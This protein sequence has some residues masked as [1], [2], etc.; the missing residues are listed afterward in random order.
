MLSLGLSI[1]LFT[2]CTAKNPENNGKISVVAVSFAEY[3]FARAVCGDAAEVSMIMKPGGEYHGYEPSF[4][5]V[6]KIAASDV[7]LYNGGESDSWIRSLLK[8][9]NFEDVMAISLIDSAKLLQKDSDGHTHSHSHD[10]H[11]DECED[12]R[13]FD[14]HIWLDFDNAI[15]MVNTICNAVCEKDEKNSAVYK[16][17]AQLYCNQIEVLK[18]IALDLKDNKE[19]D[20]IIVGDRFPYLYLTEYV[21]VKH[22][23]AIRGCGHETEA[24]PSVI[25][26]IIDK[27]REDSIEIIFCDKMSDPSI[28]QTITKE[29]T[30]KILTLN[31]CQTISKTDF[32]EGKTYINL[33]EE[34]LRNLKEALM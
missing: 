26:E 13:E 4:S 2:G 24:N 11:S 21:G 6:K 3:D 31:S 32:S 28:A 14:E 30:A 8:S 22:F 33:M 25:I 12:Y 1:I 5:D 20:Y 9:G 23:S 19:K 34:N 10:N 29:T 15:S 18:S 16:E 17:N 27:I 7:F